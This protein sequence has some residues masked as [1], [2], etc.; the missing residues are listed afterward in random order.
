LILHGGDWNDAPRRLDLGNI[1]FRKT[2]M[3]DLAFLLK[4]SQ[5]SKLIFSRNLGIDA[6]QL[7]QIDLLHAQPSQAHLA[8][9]PQI[10]GSA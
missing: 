6:M 3:P 4:I 7:K 1:D 9:L 8:L 10:F 5:R 2:H